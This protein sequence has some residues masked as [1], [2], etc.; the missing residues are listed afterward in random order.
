M[1]SVYKILK[2]NR[3]SSYVETFAAEIENNADD[4]L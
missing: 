2:N 4:F 1:V 3:R